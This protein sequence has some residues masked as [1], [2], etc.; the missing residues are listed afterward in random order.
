[1]C[2]CPSR[3]P[4]RP[5]ARC[6]DL[7]IRERGRE[8]QEAEP[9]DAGEEAQ[10]NDR[11]GG[12][13]SKPLLHLFFFFSEKEKKEKK[14]RGEYSKKRERERDSYEK[15]RYCGVSHDGGAVRKQRTGSCEPE[16]ISSRALDV[17]SHRSGR[18]VS[19]TAPDI[20]A[21]HQGSRKEKIVRVHRNRD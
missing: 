17:P 11:Q 13:E 6:R 12:V 1:M 4:K 2:Q 8:R 5:L 16:E 15:K 18:Q 9:M 20:P 10:G 7:S 21:A 19:D 3:H 14:E